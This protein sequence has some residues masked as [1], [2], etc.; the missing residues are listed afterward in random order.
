MLQAFTPSGG[1][2]YSAGVTASG[3]LLYGTTAGGGTNGDGV[4][5]SLKNK[6]K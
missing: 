5:F 4:V 1:D 6:T 2:G 3:K